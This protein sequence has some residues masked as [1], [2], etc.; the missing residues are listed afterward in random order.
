MKSG[1]NLFERHRSTRCRVFLAVLVAGLVLGGCSKKL[2]ERPE[3]LEPAN[4]KLE[5]AKVSRNE[6]SSIKVYDARVI[7]AT[8]EIYFD[9]DGY[10]YGL[11]AYPGDVL[12]EGDVIASLV[13]PNFTAIQDLEEEIEKIEADNEELYT[14]LEAEL[15]LQK[16]AGKDVTELTMDMRQDREVAELKL[17]QKKEKLEKL[18][19]NDFGYIYITAPYDCRVVASTNTREGGFISS[20]TPVIAIEVES[21]PVITCDFVSEKK[22]N[23][24]YSYYSYIHG[25]TFELE[26]LPYTKDELALLAANSIVPV[27]R[28][29]VKGD[30]LSE[31]KVGDYAAVVMVSDYKDNVLSVPINAVYSDSEGKFVYEIVDNTRIRR[32]VT[33]GISDSVNIEIID[34]VEEGA[35]VYVKN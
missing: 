12:D 17:N 4:V 14:Y 2:S 21:D 1:I 23:N 18:K 15:E 9:R 28:F 27:S 20:S 5:T 19:E 34:G 10:L 32:T 24:L 25:K 31:I 33:T 8:K 13:G 30:A 29:E 26:Y 6:M 11:Y 22:V 3:L 7:P 35:S 16:L